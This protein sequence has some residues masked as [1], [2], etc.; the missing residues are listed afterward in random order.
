MCHVPPHTHHLG[1]CPTSPS[2]PLPFALPLPPSPFP[3][4]SFRGPS[5]DERHAGDT[6][7]KAHGSLDAECFQLNGSNFEGKVHGSSSNGMAYILQLG[8]ACRC[9]VLQPSHP[10]CHHHLATTTGCAALAEATTTGPPA[11]LMRHS[12]TACTCPHL[13]LTLICANRL[14]HHRQ[15]VHLLG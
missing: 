4:S 9:L 1:L 13:M 3:L 2:L 8:V 12:R 11:T 14:R 6:E 10:H 5:P 7:D 15:Q